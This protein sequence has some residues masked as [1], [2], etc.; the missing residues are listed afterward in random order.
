MHQWAV[1]DLETTGGSPGP[2]RI[3]EIGLVLIDGCDEVK[4][5]QTLVDP[6]RSIPPFV[7]ELTGITDEM[8]RGAPSFVQVGETLH[9][10]LRDRILV[11]HN[12]SF[13]Y[14][15]IKSEL[16]LCGI[17]YDP[18]RLCTVQLGRKLFPG[19]ASYSLA[20]I[21]HDLG[22]ESFR[23]HRALGDAQAC[24]AILCKALTAHGDDKVFAL[25]KG[26]G[27]VMVLPKSWTRDDVLRIPAEPGVVRVAGLQ[28]QLLYVGDAR[29]MREKVIHL[30]SGGRRGPLWAVRQGIGSIVGV[31]TGNELLA[32][33]LANEAISQEKPLCNKA[34]RIPPRVG[35]PLGN[36]VGVGP[37]RDDGERCLLVIQKGKLAGYR[38]ADLSDGLDQQGILDGIVSIAETPDQSLF[39]QQQIQRGGGGWKWMPLV[40]E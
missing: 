5:F 20:K 32:R 28:G 14:K 17:A 27:E 26:G 37:G 16:S 22:I 2:D 30:L 29:S 11:A 8:V 12:I 19:H 34:V 15:F 9:D 13:D 38:F 33:L 4:R 36:L 1:L 10:L 40:A 7:R 18:P 35:A 3:T 6:G 25:V 24:A 39:V 21:S 23:H 31:P